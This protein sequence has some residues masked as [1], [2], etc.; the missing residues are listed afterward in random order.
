MNNYLVATNAVK[1]E[2]HRTH[3]GYFWR[4][5]HCLNQLFTKSFLLVR[6]QVLHELIQDVLVSHE[7][8]TAGPRRRVANS[9]L[10]SWLHH[11]NHRLNDC[12]C[13]EVLA[14]SLS[15]FGCRT[16]EKLLINR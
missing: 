14:R 3:S 10:R 9:V 12:A 1:I 13:S 15:R 16:L 7:K 8:K 2:V 11:V 4:K 6:V 5:L